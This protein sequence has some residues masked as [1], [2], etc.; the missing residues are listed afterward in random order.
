MTLSVFICV[1]VE[2]GLGL[3]PIYAFL[4]L[5]RLFAIFA[6]DFSLFHPIMRAC[7]VVSMKFPGLH[8]PVGQSQGLLCFFTDGRFSLRKSGGEDEPEEDSDSYVIEDDDDCYGINPAC[9][10]GEPSGGKQPSPM[11]LFLKTL[12]SPRQGWKQLRRSGI[13]PA[14]FLSGALYPLTA[15]ASVSCFI[16]MAYDRN[17]ELSA[18]LISAVATF[19]SFFLGYFL[20][21]VFARIFLRGKGAKAI[22]TPFGKIFTACSLSSLALFGAVGKLLPML[23]AVTFFLPLWTVYMISRGITFLCHGDRESYSAVIMSVLMIGVPL[24]CGYFFPLI[25]TL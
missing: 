2:A 11:L 12:V 1:F 17:A 25:L 6:A 5:W 15:L 7:N 13:E 24:L 10:D 14:R 22:D 3:L 19:I 20:I 9:G 8:C 21:Q 23:E 4:H 16:E 18:V